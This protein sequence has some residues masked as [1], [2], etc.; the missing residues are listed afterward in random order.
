MGVIFARKSS[1][2]YIS[3]IYTRNTIS[4]IK[5]NIELSKLKETVISGDNT[6]ADLKETQR[7]TE[8]NIN[9]IVYMC[10]GTKEITDVLVY[11][12]IAAYIEGK[13]RNAKNEDIEKSEMKETKNS[14][15]FE[16]EKN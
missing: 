4:Y 9:N 10:M 6:D 14:S 11:L 1:T 3:T 12:G 2:S 5:R 8:S 7:V 13:I 15:E 16:K